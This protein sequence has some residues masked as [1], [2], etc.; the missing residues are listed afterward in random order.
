[1]NPETVPVK[2]D[3]EHGP[4][5][6]AVMEARE[7]SFHDSER[8]NVTEVRPRVRVASDPTFEADPQADDHWTIRRRAYAVHQTF[9]LWDRTM[10][11]NGDLWHKESSPYAGG[12]RNDRRG[13]VEFRTATWELMHMATVKALGEFAAQY[14]G[15]E[16]LSRYLL[17]KHKHDREIYQVVD[18]RAQA[19]KHEAAAVKL[20]GEMAPVFDGL[21][22]DMLSLLKA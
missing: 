20:A 6:V 16:E 4:L 3:T 11:A 22:G 18:L 12:Y 10:H 5:Y 8:G 17:V 2:I 7:D 15:W 9:Y 19:S 14:K 1:M 13:Q 21:S